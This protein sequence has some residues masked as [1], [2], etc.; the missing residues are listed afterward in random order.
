MSLHVGTTVGVIVAS[1]HSPILYKAECFCVAMVPVFFLHFMESSTTARKEV[2]E[3][4]LFP[5]ITPNAWKMANLQI[6]FL[7]WRSFDIGAIMRATL[8]IGPASAESCDWSGLLF[9][10]TQ[11]RNTKAL[12]TPG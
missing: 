9:Q 3:L 10:A 5:S 11:T 1:A 4:Q 12:F 2:L 8:R 6:A 7:R